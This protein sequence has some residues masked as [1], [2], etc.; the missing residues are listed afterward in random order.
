MAVGDRLGQ[1]IAVG[2]PADLEEAQCVPDCLAV[3]LVDI[4]RILHDAGR[5]G[6][7][8]LYRVEVVE[9][10]PPLAV[11]AAVALVDDDQVEIARRYF[12]YSLTRVCR[13][14]IVMRFS[15]W[16]RRPCAARD[17]K[18]N[19]QVLGEG[20]F[21]L[22]GERVAIDDEQRARRPIGLEQALEQ[23][24]RRTGLAGPVAISTSILRRPLTISRHR[25]SMQA[26]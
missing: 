1:A 5:R 11:N 3:F 4:R 20:V 6:Q 7:P 18:A 22:N 2:R 17:S 19:R 8:D 16:K 24:G 14:T 9:R 10:A 26:V 25:M 12:S 21:G 13:V 23:G 15:S